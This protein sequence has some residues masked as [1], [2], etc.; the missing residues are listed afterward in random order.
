MV[1]SPRARLQCGFTLVELVMVIAITGILAAVVVPRFASR[2]DF[3]LA[4]F[5]EAARAALRLA[6]KTAVAQHRSVS[7]NLDSSAGKISLC[8]DS[9]YPCATPL[10]DPASSGA[11]KVSAPTGIS[12]SSSATQLI[13]DWTGSPNGTGTTLTVSGG[14]GGTTVVVTVDANTGYVY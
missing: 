14:T 1:K 10:A 9:A 8:Y 6:Q 7:A 2:S 3:E 5:A 12:L 4:G 13:F 11:F